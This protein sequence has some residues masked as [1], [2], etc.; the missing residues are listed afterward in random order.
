MTMGLIKGITPDPVQMFHNIQH[1]P[2]FICLQ[3]EELWILKH[4]WPEGIWKDCGHVSS[5]TAK[6]WLHPKHENIMKQILFFNLFGSI[7]VQLFLHSL[8]LFYFK[9]ITLTQRFLLYLEVDKSYLWQ[10]FNYNS[11]EM[12]V[13]SD[14]RQLIMRVSV[15]KCLPLL[16]W[17]HIYY[18]IYEYMYFKMF[19]IIQP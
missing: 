3:C 13:L 5:I 10:D 9:G 8:F 7:L 2:Y 4:I 1:M 18:N 6:V 11:V 15:L 19:N 14:Q 16:G 17:L 12:F